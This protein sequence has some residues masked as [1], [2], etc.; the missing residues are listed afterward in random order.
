MSLGIRSGRVSGGR[1]AT[2]KGGSFP[3]LDADDALL[4]IE[5]PAP[6]RR[7]EVFKST[8][9]DKFFPVGKYMP[10]AKPIRDGSS[11]FQKKNYPN[12]G[13]GGPLLSRILVS[14][15]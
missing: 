14:Q 13:C 11:V 8:C 15:G 4:T 9:W 12:G 3:G 2:C 10:P 7:A 1:L 5:R 6:V